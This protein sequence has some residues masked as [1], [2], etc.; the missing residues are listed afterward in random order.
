MLRVDAAER[1]SGLGWRQRSKLSMITM[2]PPQQGHDGRWCARSWGSVANRNEVR[3]YLV[4]SDMSDAITA[5]FE[6]D[7]ACRLV[8]RQSEFQ[9]AR[10]VLEVGG[11]DFARIIAL[12]K[13]HPKKFFISLDFRLESKAVGNLA[14]ATALPNLSVVKA[15]I[16]E[17]IL[18][19]ATFDFVFSIAVMEHVPQLEQFLHTVFELL[20]PRGVYASFQ[21]PFWTSKTGHHFNHA[22]PAVRKVL[23]SYEHIRFDAEGM[24]EYLQT[25]ADLPFKADECVRKI[26]MRSDLSRLS[27]IETRRIVQASPFVTIEWTERPDPDFEEAKAQA[28]LKAHGD[29]YTLADFR[30]GGAFVRLLKA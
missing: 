2:R 19:P 27:S 4:S 7:W 13:R 22:D 18:A 3:S 23:N 21:A 17:R 6:P 16:L 11:G 14:R 26:Y 8:E 1:G 24:R 25:I 12:A 15:D 9:R 10:R 5:N 30:V 20:A 28:A 29:R